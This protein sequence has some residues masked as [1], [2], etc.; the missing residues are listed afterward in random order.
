MSQ[1]LTANPRPPTGFFEDMRP[2]MRKQYPGRTSEERDKIIAGIFWKY[3]EKTRKRLIE[4]YDTGIRN[5]KA[6]L[7]EC[8]ICKHKNPV[9]K[10]GVYLK[11]GKC[12]RNLVSVKVKRKK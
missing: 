5:P 2:K 6:E 3:P 11:C 12:H 9:S 8:P 7:L 1:S 4:E 10:A